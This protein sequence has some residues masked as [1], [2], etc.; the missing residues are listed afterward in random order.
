MNSFIEWNSTC[1]ITAD[2]NYVCEIT[3]RPVTGMPIGLHERIQQ[4]LV[5]NVHN[6]EL[7][8]IIAPYFEEITCHICWTCF[9]NVLARYFRF[10]RSCMPWTPVGMR[11]NDLFQVESVENILRK[12]SQGRGALCKVQGLKRM[13]DA[14]RLADSILVISPGDTR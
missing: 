2:L 1:H 5:L 12:P 8:T 10:Q 13:A 3:L 14:F 6:E 4:F 7:T 11:T 9:G